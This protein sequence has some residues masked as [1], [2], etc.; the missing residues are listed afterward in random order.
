MPQNPLGLFDTPPDRRH[1][2]FS[3]AIVCLLCASLPLIIPVRSVRLPP[4]DAFIPTVDAILF[5][6]E[7]I[8]ATLL[9]AQASVFR[10]RALVALASGFLLTAL[11]IV[12][13]ALTFP[14][15]FA[16]EGLLDAGVNTTAWL[17]YG[18]RWACAA[19]VVLYVLLKR[20][21]A[22]AAPGTD[23]PPV[24]ILA[25]I[26]A[27][28]ALALAVTLFT[29]VGHD[30][31]PPYFSNR[32]DVI[33]GNH[34]A[35]QGVL[36]CA[37]IVAGV[38]LFRARTSVLDIWLLVAVS[39]WLIEVALT[40][41]LPGRFTLGWYWIWSV[42]VFSHLIVM[43]ALL[44]ESNR[45]YARLALAQVERKRERLARLMSLDAVAAAISHEVEQPLTAIRLHAGTGKRRLAASPADIRTALKALDGVLEAAQRT[46]DVIR[47]IRAMFVPKRGKRSEFNLND[48]VRSTVALMDLDLVAH[49]VSVY[50]DLDEQLAPV[51][52]DPVQIQRV[53]VN[54]VTNAIEALE[55][56]D[57]YPRSITIRST[58]TEGQAVL[59]EICDNGLG[60]APEAV[61]QIFEVYFT[62][63]KAGVGLGLSLSRIIIEA[64]G[65]RLWASPNPKRG[66]TFHLEMPRSDAV[67]E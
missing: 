67:A 6:G 42:V 63:K 49:R 11:L 4:V 16:P 52:A 10:S 64:T 47:S 65:G 56:V 30:L 51:L 60:I 57:S 3:L 48:M 41:T 38:M 25:S 37:F 43:L 54:L 40:L 24:R 58:A 5:L 15:A 31:L 62:T 21:D 17:T 14:G 33:M 53:L 55:E 13:H 36:F 9:Y 7:V 35:F 1:I 19:T 20:A 26:L 32:S 29:T 18:R 28:M 27:T 2:R 22:A 12:P 59:L 50:L 44:A 39:G 46:S 23:R 34:L 8:T 45:L 61:E 66:A